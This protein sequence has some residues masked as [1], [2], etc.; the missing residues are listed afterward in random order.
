[1][2]RA[3]EDDAPAGERLTQAIKL[4]DDAKYQDALS[5]LE[6][7]SDD[8][9]EQEEQQLQLQ[10]YLGLAQN[11]V[12]SISNAERCLK[13]GLDALKAGKPDRAKALL[14]KVVSN[15][16][17]PQEMKDQA[18]E[19]L[20]DIERP[21]KPSTASKATQGGEPKAPASRGE[22]RPPA[23]TATERSA[24]LPEPVGRPAAP[25]PSSGGSS[26]V[27]QLSEEHELLWQQAANTYRDTEGQIRKAVL[28]ENFDE[29]RRLL[30][31]ARQTVE[32]N[33]RY[34]SP[35]SQYEDLLAQA[36]ELERFVADEEREFQEREI[37]KKQQEIAQQEDER[38]A[39]I[40][41]T[42]ARQVEQLMQQA[43]EL[44]KE[45]RYDD[46]VQVLKQVLAIEPDNSQAAWMKDTIEDFAIGAR[47]REIISTRESEAQDAYVQ[48]DEAMI[49]WHKDIMYPKNWPEISARRTGIEE[50]GESDATRSARRKLQ[51]VA[52]ELKFEAQRF[53]D[54]IDQLR[55]LTGLNIVPNWAA[56]G[57]SAIEKDVEV[58]LKPLQ[59]VKYEKALQLILDQ[60]GGGETE[61]AFEID[62]GVIRVSTKE[63]LSRNKLTRVYDVQDL[64]ISIPTFRS[65]FPN[66]G[67]APQPQNQQ[68]GLGGGRFLFGGGGGAGG[69]GGGQQQG[70]G[71]GQGQQE[72]QQQQQGN[73]LE[74]IMTLIQQTIDPESWRESGGNVGSIQPLNKQIIITQTATAHAQIRDLLKQLRQ[75]RALQVAVEARYITITRNWLEQIGVD[76]DVVLNSGNAGFDRTTIQDPATGNPVLVPRRFTQLGFTP[77]APGNVGIGMPTQPFGQP[78]GQPGLV[79]AGAQGGSNNWSPI[80]IINNTLALATPA[81]TNIPGSL[82]STANDNPAFQM[83]GS[84]LDN[85]Q[86]D[87]LLR[88]T[89]VDRRAS[90]LDAPR[91]V[92]FNG[93]RAT[94]ESFVEQ[95]YIAA[96]TPII[97]D[98]AG[99]FLPNVATAPT[100]RSLDVQA[101]VSA[102]HRYV[103]LT[104]RTFTTIT[105]DFRTVFFGGSS[106]VGSGFIELAT[107]RNQDVRTTVSVPDGGTLLI[108]GLK[109]AA[110]RDI[111]A[112]VP[113]LSRIPILKRAYS[114][115]SNVK[116]DQ[117][118]LVLLKPTI[119]IQEEAEAEA[120][121][122]LSAA[123]GR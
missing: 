77:G 8:D 105:G 79:P 115:T 50:A 123:S 25:R 42:K 87:F 45:R 22:P 27:E 61:L 65:R 104:V 7:I 109:L 114:N 12:N 100:G 102:D 54:V 19:K 91:L 11:A 18:A 62:D 84:F 64:I 71:G 15:S 99:A 72:E 43:T 95:D 112:G 31:F 92:L 49:P 66:S 9:L 23:R 34:A 63:D 69:A 17:A 75:A 108:A 4:Y 90:D 103:T 57:A 68:G 33:R 120:F 53:E 14:E 13:E 76:L 74:P 82:A 110:E 35:P 81:D 96:L 89:Q 55:A 67:S 16:F 44:R 32:L 101:T 48:N 119:I 113:I 118:L 111:D 30:D 94:F 58:N 80:P 107:R 93:Q 56:L 41:M 59:N 86:V 38:V 36:V 98:N 83:F 47:D 70:G 51:S 88:A 52:P 1:L 85:I 5:I 117:V 73:P 116:D 40:R 46:A 6:G 2:A 39:R 24:Q 97:G 121:P 106:T 28:A 26:I 78:Y 20:K 122:T 3:N 29:A 21:V 10:R 37:Q 60:V